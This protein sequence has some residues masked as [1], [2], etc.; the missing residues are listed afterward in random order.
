M[1]D[2]G[3]ATEKPIKNNIVY[4]PFIEGIFFKNNKNHFVALFSHFGFFVFSVCSL[5]TDIAL[6]VRCNTMICYEKILQESNIEHICSVL[7][8]LAVFSPY[9]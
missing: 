7:F 3:I 5:S 6:D 8:C 1:L 4:S 2:Y 9:F